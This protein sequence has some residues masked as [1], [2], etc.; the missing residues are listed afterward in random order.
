[1]LRKL[2]KGVPDVTLVAIVDDITIVGPPDSV[3]TVLQRAMT[4]LP[5]LG[6]KLSTPKSRL[7]LP[8]ADQHLPQEHPLSTI[9]VLRGA[10][11]LLGSIVGLDRQAI[12]DFAL[13]KVKR[14]DPFFTALR[15]PQF[16]TQHAF[17]LLRASALPR[18]NLQNH[19][20]SP[21]STSV[22]TL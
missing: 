14:H 20:S 5:P 1:V 19:S 6:L 7:L 21:S 13:Q 18:M 4:L 9:T 8:S 12:T 15:H 22:S 3:A 10:M 11:P 17:L 2:I 16:K